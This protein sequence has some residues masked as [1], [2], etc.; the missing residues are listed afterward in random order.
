MAEAFGKNTQLQQ[1][2]LTGVVTTGNVLGTGFFGSVEDVSHFN[3][4]SS[5][6]C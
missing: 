1:F 3:R 2:I 5:Y 6:V 4:N